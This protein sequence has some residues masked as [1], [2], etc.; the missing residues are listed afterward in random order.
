M[1]LKQL[2]IDNPQITAALITALFGIAGIFINILINLWFRNRD[3]KYKNLMQQI[4]S[5]ENY[6]IP[7]SEITTHFIQYIQAIIRSEDDDLYSILD[8]NI[9]AKYSNSI[10]ILK[11]NLKSY[12]SFLSQTKYKYPSNYKLFKLHKKAKEKI[13]LLSQYVFQNTKLSSIEPAKDTL[14][15]LDELIYQI[16]QYEASTLIDNCIVRYI[17]KFRIW[18]SHKRL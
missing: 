8:D 4:E 16:Q 6:Y 3:Y 10:R 14:S 1:N 9:G 13:F 12:N 5:L 15:L 18:K 11:E 2:I 7:L 17:E